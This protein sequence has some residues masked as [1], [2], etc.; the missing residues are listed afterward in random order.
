MLTFRYEESDL[1]QIVLFLAV[2]ATTA[3][4]TDDADR[5]RRIALTDDLTGLHNLRSFELR[6]LAMVRA[7]RAA[8]TPLALLVLDV[9]RLKSLNDRY[10]HLAG[11]E[12]VRTVGHIIGQRLPSDAVGCRYGGDEFVVA[13]PQST[14][15]EAKPSRRRSASGGSCLCAC[16]GRSCLSGRNALDQRRRRQRVVR[17]RFGGRGR[18]AAGTSKAA[19]RSSAPQTPRS[20]EPRP[21]AAIRSA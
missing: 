7:S 9:D 1:I 11:A 17:A 14:A 15:A 12:A 10:G 16:A 5:L 13:V 19:R 18:A 3:R 2:G 6:L 8:R 20:I 21:W 4:F